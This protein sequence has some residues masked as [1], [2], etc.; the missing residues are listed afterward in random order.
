[1]R[2]IILSVVLAATPVLAAVASPNDFLD[3]AIKGDN[4]EIKLGQ[5]AEKQGSS[6]QVRDFGK[7][8][9][10]DHA[11]A[12]SQAA[13]VA[14][15]AGVTVSEDPMP[16]AQQE[17]DKLAALSGSAFD[18]E[19]ARYMVEDHQKDIA[20]FQKEAQAGDAKVSPLA[21]RQLPTLEKHLK[22]AQSLSADAK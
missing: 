15:A 16:E 11:K 13:K 12:K 19:F 17:Y 8:L 20:D 18:S 6:A 7:K 21:K 10:A 22:I 14:K 1:M 9:A 4:S 3:T 5:L 2:R